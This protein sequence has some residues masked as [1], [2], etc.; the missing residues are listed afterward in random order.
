METVQATVSLNTESGFTTVEKE[1]VGQKK[2]SGNPDN[3]ALCS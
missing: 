1:A 2:T 3:A